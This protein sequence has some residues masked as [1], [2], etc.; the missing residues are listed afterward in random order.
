MTWTRA[1]FGLEAPGEVVGMAT[2]ESGV[3]TIT[4]GGYVHPVGDDVC[5]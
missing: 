5:P 3:V 1:C 2:T 4:E